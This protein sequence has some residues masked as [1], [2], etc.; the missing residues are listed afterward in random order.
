MFPH[1]FYLSRQMVLRRF[2]LKNSLRTCMSLICKK[3]LATPYPGEND[4][5]KIVSTLPEVA[6]AQV[7]AFLTEWIF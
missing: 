7:S 2:F 3:N 1:K 4:L 5:H 6:S